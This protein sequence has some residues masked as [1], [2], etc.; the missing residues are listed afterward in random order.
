MGDAKYVAFQTLLDPKRMPGQQT[1]VLLWPY[2]EGL[3]LD[4]AM[5]PLT[6]LAIGLYGHELPPQNGA[7]LRLVVPWKYG[8]KGIKSIVK[9]TL[10]AKQ[11]RDDLERECAERV[12]VLLE[13]EPAGRPPALEPGDRAADRRGA[14]GRRSCSTATPN[15][16][17]ISTRAWT[18]GPT[19]KASSQ[20]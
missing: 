18:C 9:I 4:E 3:R 13:R 2:V 6:I 17:P 11:P 19:S 12:R 16:W 20:A 15:R 5:H 8:F 7:P 10:V 14:A 1:D